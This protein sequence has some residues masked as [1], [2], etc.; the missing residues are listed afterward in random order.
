M[1]DFFYEADKYYNTMVKIRRKL[2]MHPELGRD[3]FFTANLVE[4]I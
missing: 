2:H 4:S 3:L 1:Y